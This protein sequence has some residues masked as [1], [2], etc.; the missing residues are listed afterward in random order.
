MSGYRGLPKC[1]GRE[2]DVRAC[3]GRI[4]ITECARE[5]SRHDLERIAR[6]MGWLGQGATART[7]GA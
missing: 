5:K 3:A 1:Y 7:A 6:G 2:F 4:F